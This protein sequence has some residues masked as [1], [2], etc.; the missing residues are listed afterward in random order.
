MKTID[1]LKCARIIIT[2]FFLIPFCVDL[3]GQI[4]VRISPSS[5]KKVDVTNNLRRAIYQEQGRSN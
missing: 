5:K 1:F 4:K 3:S 2:L